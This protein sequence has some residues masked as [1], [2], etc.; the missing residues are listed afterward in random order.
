VR[1]AVPKT[2]E[3]V[4]VSFLDLL[5]I[6]LGGVMLL[7]VLFS[8]S[9]RPG[10]ATDEADFLVVGVELELEPTSKQADAAALRREL[11]GGLIPKL[12]LTTTE[13]PEWRDEYRRDSEFHSL[14][15]ADVRWLTE[16]VEDGSEGKLVG[17][18]RVYCICTRMR[19]TITPSLTLQADPTT[20][21]T[22]R[23]HYWVSTRDRW[24]KGDFPLAP[25]SRM[26]ALETVKVV[27]Q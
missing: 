17:T 4:S 10:Q 27:G 18:V 16:F 25:G 1:D 14:P 8:L 3:V 13:S 12:Q 22:R 19:H 9:L 11:E 5:S 7:A 20:L 21:R 2:I 6:A 24:S 23:A 15:F 26:I